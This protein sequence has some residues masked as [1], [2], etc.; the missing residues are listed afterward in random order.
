M[1]HKEGAGAEIQLLSMQMN[2]SAAD[3]QGHITNLMLATHTCG[4][5]SPFLLSTCMK[6]LHPWITSWSDHGW[7]T[8]NIKSMHQ[9]E[10]PSPLQYL[11]ARLTLT[12]SPLSFYLL[13][14]RGMTVSQVTG[15]FARP[16]R[17]IQ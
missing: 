8:L 1:D 12:S 13:P 11:V 14:C 7:R 15:I 6:T 3:L 5:P 16:V 2:V 9:K 10:K 4:V 17:I